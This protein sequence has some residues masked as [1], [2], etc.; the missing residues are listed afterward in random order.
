MSLT[1]HMKFVGLCTF[2]QQGSR[3]YVVLPPTTGHHHH[4]AH[5]GAHVPE[6]EARLYLGQTNPKGGGRVPWSIPLDRVIV[7]ITDRTPA[8]GL[9][10]MPAPLFDM[11]KVQAGA[12]LNPQVIDA[13]PPA[14]LVR[15]R[16]D[17]ALHGILESVGLGRFRFKDEHGADVGDEVLMGTYTTWTE[18][19]GLDDL[20]V[21]LEYLDDKG[22]R[23]TIDLTPTQPDPDLGDGDIFIDVYHVPKDELPP[24]EPKKVPEGTRVDHFAAY[25]PQ[26]TGVRSQPMPVFVK[27]DETTTAGVKKGGETGGCMN[28][29]A[30]LP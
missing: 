1:L 4:G 8:T 12:R 5:Q 13:N 18:T 28:V 3:T 26:L 20:Q 24:H 19:L 17:L 6:H 23:C 29:F 25:Y 16:I 10:T 2:T 7:R 15:A 11:T 22:T 14:D 9:P 30:P 21:E 27:K